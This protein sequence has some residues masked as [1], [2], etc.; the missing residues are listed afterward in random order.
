MIR[1]VQQLTIAG[2]VAVRPD[3]DVDPRLILQP[4]VEAPAL[5]AARQ[6]GPFRRSLY[7]SPLRS[8]SVHNTSSIPSRCAIGRR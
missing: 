4:L 3:F 2:A 7:R 1:P 8:E 6:F 5:L